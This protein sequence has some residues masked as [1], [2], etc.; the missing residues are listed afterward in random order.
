MFGQTKSKLESPLYR[1][2]PHACAVGHRSLSR[3]TRRKARTS[4]T[5]YSTRRS[6]NSPVTAR[7]EAAHGDATRRHR[8]RI[9]G[10]RR[11][12]RGF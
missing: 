3:A 8:H 1:L 4:A 9:G 11:A 2:T 6:S 5:S 10:G 12:R 7:P